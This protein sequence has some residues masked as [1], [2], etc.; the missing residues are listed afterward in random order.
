MFQ[1]GDILLLA[2]TV[3]G[4]VIALRTGVNSVYFLISTKS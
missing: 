2:V 1:E 4:L 3:Q